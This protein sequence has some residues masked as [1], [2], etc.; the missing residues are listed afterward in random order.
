MVHTL[1]FL[2]RSNGVIMRT[3][4]WLFVTSSTALFSAATSAAAVQA[5][6]VS[7]SSSTSPTTVQ[8]PPAQQFDRRAYL[9]RNVRAQE[10]MLALITRKLAGNIQDPAVRQMLESARRVTVINLEEAVRQLQKFDAGRK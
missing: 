10:E 7:T 4:H 3:K 8:A 6:Q 1:L 9:E 5:Q 2:S